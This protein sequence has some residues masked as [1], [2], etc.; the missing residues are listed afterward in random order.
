M[1][2]CSLYLA[3]S[4]MSGKGNNESKLKNVPCVEKITMVHASPCHLKALFSTTCC[5]ETLERQGLMEEKEKK[6]K[7]NFWISE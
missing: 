1:G 5:A 3:N 2:P 6:T 7:N 4:S